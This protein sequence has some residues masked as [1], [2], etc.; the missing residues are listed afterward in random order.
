M[1]TE[2]ILISAAAGLLA[3]AAGYCCLAGFDPETVRVR[4]FFR[5]GLRR[6][7]L[8]IMGAAWLF[9]LASV[10]YGAHFQLFS[11]IQLTM[12]S[13]TICWLFTIGR[14]DW[15]YRLIPNR[16]LLVGL[17]LWPVLALLEI[18]VA[19]NSLRTVLWYSGMGLIIPFGLWIIALVA[20]GAFGMGDVKLFAIL[21]L[22]YG[23]TGTFVILFFTTVIMAVLAIVLLVIK[24]ATKKTTL[25]MAPFVVIGFL[26]AT[27]VG[28]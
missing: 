10:F 24:K 11:G 16:V 6:G 8:V 19:G 18:F 21:G 3:A 17:A 28:I 14:I 20:K 1:E 27:V 22:F 9:S 15:Q 2:W 5:P 13:L 4:N 23:L 12:H 7:P 26:L 25:P